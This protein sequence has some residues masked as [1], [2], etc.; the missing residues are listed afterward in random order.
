MKAACQMARKFN[1]H[2][3]GLHTLQSIEVYPGIVV[4]L[5]RQATDFFAKSQMQQAEKI[6][7][8]F[9]KHTAGEDFVAE[10]RL[11]KADA[12]HAADRMAEERIEILGKLKMRHMGK[13]HRFPGRERN[14][15]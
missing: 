6:Q 14:S 15:T 3:I 9:D 13:P 8:V 10:W 4:D 11:V 7:A 1:A 12:N 5:P 2:L